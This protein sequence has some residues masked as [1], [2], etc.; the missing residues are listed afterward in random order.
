MIGPGTYNPNLPERDVPT[1]S[2]GMDATRDLFGTPPDVP[3]PGAYNIPEL[4]TKLPVAIS[5][6]VEERPSSSVRKIHC[7]PKAWT[8]LANETNAVFKFQGERRIFPPGDKTPDPGYYNPELPSGKEAGDR[9]SFSVRSKRQEIFPTVE[10]PGPGTYNIKDKWIKD[11]RPTTP[12]AVSEQVIPTAFVPGPGAYDTELKRK[13]DKR[14][15]SVFMSRSKRT[16]SASTDPPG[17]GQYSPKIIDEYRKVP[18]KIRQTRYEK[19]GDWLEQ[20]KKKTP[21][22]DAYQNLEG[23]LRRG[24]TIP[25]SPRFEHEHRNRVPGPGTYEVKHGTMFR[26]SHNSSI[27]RMPDD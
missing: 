20:S 3:G 27:P 23:D 6:R 8:S 15:N 18:K 4:N 11:K 9:S 7:G 14:P 24:R 19:V 21:A 16:S 17:P 12:R 22:P 1:I 2:L 13:I 26:R 10:T 25:K 5:K